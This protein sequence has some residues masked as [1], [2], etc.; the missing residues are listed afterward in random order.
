MHISI[1]YEGVLALFNIY[2]PRHLSSNS[3]SFYQKKSFIDRFLINFWDVMQAWEGRWWWLLAFFHSQ[4][5]RPHKTIKRCMPLIMKWKECMIFVFMV[6]ASFICHELLLNSALQ[7]RLRTKFHRNLEWL[8]KLC[9]DQT[10]TNIDTY[11][12]LMSGQRRCMSIPTLYFFI[13]VPFLC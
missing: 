9:E 2:N 1:A 12:C 3:S 8:A 7:D 10:C 4:T 11:I 13:Y 6:L 5:Q